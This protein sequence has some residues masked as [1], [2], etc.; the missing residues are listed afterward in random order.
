MYLQLKKELLNLLN[1]NISSI[2]HQNMVNFG[3]VLATLHLLYLHFNTVI[4]KNIYIIEK[5][6]REIKMQGYTNT[7]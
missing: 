7:I 3:P 1:S 2:C 6:E 5:G 4:N